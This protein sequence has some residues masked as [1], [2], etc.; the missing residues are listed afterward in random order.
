MI[1]RISFGI[2]LAGAAL[3]ALVAATGC[4]TDAYCFTCVSGTGGAGGSSSSGSTGTATGGGGGTIFLDGGSDADVDGDAPNDACGADT[5]NDPKNCGFC[6]NVCD[7]FGAFPTCVNGKCAIDTCAIGHIDL[8]GI[9][10]DGCEYTC[11]PS[12]GGVEICDNKDNDCDG[13]IDEDFDLDGDPQNCGVCGN[14]CSLLNATATCAVVN[15]FP[16]CVVDFCDAG[17]NDLDGLD[18]TGCEYACPVFPPVAEVCNDKDDNC[19][20]Q[21]NEGNPGGGTP[22]TSTCPNGVCLGECT[23][24]TTV[25]AGASIVC[26]GG[27]GPTIEVCDNKDNDCDGVVDDGFDLQNDPLNCGSCGNVCSLPNAISGCVAGNCVITTCLPGF[28]SND[29]NA[30]NGC[31]YTCPVS[32]PTVESC[33]GVDDDC[34][35]IVDDP[36]VI[37][38][39]KPAQALCYPTPGTPC[40]GADFTCKGAMGW[41]CNYSASVEVDGA[42]KLALVE[43]KC[44]GVDGNCNGQIDEAFS[45]LGSQCDNGLLGACRDVGQRVCDPN[46]ASQTL[47]D[48]SFPPD[49]VPNSPSAEACNGVDDDCNGQI[50]DGIVDDQVHIVSGGL[51]FFIDRYEASRPGATAVFAGLDE[52]RRCVLPGVLPW[53]FTTQAEAAAACAA[54]G[55][56]LCTVAEMQ[57]ACEGAANSAYPYGVSYQPLT[58]NGLDYD[59]VPGGANDDV[60]LPTGS[61]AACVTPTAVFDLSGN[62]AEW[63]STVTGNTGPPK[64]LSIYEAKGGSYKTP[65]LGLTCQFDLSR[66]ASNAILSELGFRCCHD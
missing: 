55:D 34:N 52:T 60:L 10:S 49:A 22:C 38:P 15:G 23:P 20:G 9:A 5:E 16:T 53:T 63:T 42:G 59:G 47:C 27:A 58:C 14:V 35:G 64:N 24:G 12:N 2:A 40:A 17:F 44:D 21:V 61:L 45:D 62:A 3:G 19:D 33:N 18:Q 56:R 29:N 36:A 1:A 39:Q 48:L 13:E 65:A 37:A 28:A 46:D 7:L 51:N 57:E 6:G 26:V 11:S 31:E 41:R 25:C 50:D 4:A 8:N 30:Q 32:P 43:T 54:S 66:F